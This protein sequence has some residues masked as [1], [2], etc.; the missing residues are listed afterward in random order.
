M[1]TSGGANGTLRLQYVQSSVLA[2]CTSRSFFE[3]SHS[4]K[5]QQWFAGMSDVD[6]FATR[7]QRGIAAAVQ[8]LGIMAQRV[9]P[10]SAALSTITEQICGLLLP[11]TMETEPVE[12]LP[13]GAIKPAQAAYW[14]T[15]GAAFALLMLC[16]G[17]GAAVGAD[18]SASG[19]AP[20][21]PAHHSDPRYAYGMCLLALRRAE[22]AAKRRDSK[23]EVLLQAFHDAGAPERW[24]QLY[25]EASVRSK[26]LLLSLWCKLP[27]QQIMRCDGA[28]GRRA[29]PSLARWRKRRRH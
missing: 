13:P 15:E 8:A 25:H 17:P 23:S 16:D 7:Y 29:G 12:Q 18:G 20:T 14:V 10:G 24:R 5:V 1:L 21:M 28:T 26:S 22:C 2:C 19:V 6:E 11:L 27:V 4:A 3:Q 9:L